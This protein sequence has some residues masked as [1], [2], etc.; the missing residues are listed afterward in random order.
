MN[1]LKK[2][3]QQQDLRQRVVPK[4]LSK[5][6]GE[7]RECETAIFKPLRGDPARGNENYKKSR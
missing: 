1:A 6:K 2:L 7:V 4:F 3:R 5:I